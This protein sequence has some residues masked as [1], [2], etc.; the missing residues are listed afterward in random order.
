MGRVNTPFLVAW[1]YVRGRRKAR[2]AQWVTRASALGL[3][4]GTAAM[5][6]VLSAFNGLEQSILDVYRPAYPAVLG[7]PDSTGNGSLSAQQVARLRRAWSPV[8]PADAHLIPVY[9]RQVLLR[10][11]LNEAVVTLTV[12]SPEA[13][14]HWPWLPNPTG[15]HLGS[16]VAQALGLSGLRDWPALEVWIPSQSDLELNSLMDL[17]PQLQQGVFQPDGEFTVHPDVDAHRA[18]VVWTPAWAQFLGWDSTYTHL[19]WIQ[20]AEPR[21]SPSDWS[22]W[23]AENPDRAKGVRWI[24][25]EEQQSALFRVLRTERLATL[26]ILTLV[27]FLASLGLYG[28][29]VLL[30]LEKGQ[31]NQS[32]H[33]MGASWGQIATI[34]RYNGVL[35]GALGAFGGVLLGSALVWGQQTF[36]WVE[37]GTGFA[38]SAY[39]V[40][41]TWESAG[42]SFAIAWGLSA[43]ASAWAARESRPVR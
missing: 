12:L 8:L 13:A 38:L 41:W 32:L 15:F 14:S 4:V 17:E 26:G 21:W 7:Q 24:P 1:R 25:L 37:L 5:V 40:R 28:A 10:N 11:G 31:E 2:M 30:A 22:R 19:D 42:L 43:L 20:P 3:A 29:T 27:V 9:E 33:A 6:V 34:Y 35:V 23:T 39:P 36:G 18:L 16:G